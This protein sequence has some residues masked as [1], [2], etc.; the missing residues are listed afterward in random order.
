MSKIVS[1][2]LPVVFQ[3][4][5]GV[6]SSGTRKYALILKALEIPLSLV[7]WALTSLAT[8]APVRSSNIYLICSD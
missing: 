4:V 1:R 8:F 7:G 2:F 5:A 6:V 3:F